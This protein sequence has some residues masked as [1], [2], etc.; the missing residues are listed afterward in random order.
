MLGFG[1]EYQ[2]L[3]C[4]VKEFE[5]ARLRRQLANNRKGNPL[6]PSGRAWSPYLFLAIKSLGLLEILRMALDGGVS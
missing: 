2:L 3:E 1:C 4:H 5:D 6:R